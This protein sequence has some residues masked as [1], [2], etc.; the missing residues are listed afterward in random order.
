M[1]PLGH[2][3]LAAF[4]AAACVPQ[5]DRPHSVSAAAPVALDAQ[6]IAA[7]DAGIRRAVYHPE[8]VRVGEMAAARD[9]LGDITVCGWVE[10]NFDSNPPLEPFFGTLRTDRG[11]PL[12]VRIFYG[13]KGVGDVTYEYIRLECRKSGIRILQDS[14]PH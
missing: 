7:V 2:A 14:L 9:A 8:S 11:K 5:A 4:L 1:R 12:F 13:E 3:A 6:Q 10:A